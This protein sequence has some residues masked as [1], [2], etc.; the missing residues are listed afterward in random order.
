MSR[1]GAIIREATDNGFGAIVVGR[2]GISKVEEF[3]LGRVSTKVIHGGE[4]IR[5]GLFNTGENDDKSIKKTGWMAD[6]SQQHHL[7]DAAAGVILLVG[8]IRCISGT[9]YAL[10]VFFM[11]PIVFIAWYAGTIPGVFMAFFSTVVWLFADLYLRDEFS[12]PE[13]PFINEN[14]P[15]DC[16][17]ICGAVDGN[18]ENA[19]DTQKKLPVRTSSPVWPIV[20]AS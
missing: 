14:V 8:I 10:S 20:C 7:D 1:A 16:V 4:T 18:F 17:F 5:C 12:T 15:A 11:F 3:F 6:E 2:R 9:E 13:V 19:L